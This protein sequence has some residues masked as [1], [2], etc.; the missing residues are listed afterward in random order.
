MEQKRFLHEK[1][2]LDCFIAFLDSS[3]TIQ[4]VALEGVKNFLK[5]GDQEVFENGKTEN[6]YQKELVLRGAGKIIRKLQDSKDEE[7]SY[8]ARE[9]LNFYPLESQDADSDSSY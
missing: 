7:I 9:I 2:V 5:A 8:K 1:G 6:P 4:E 3:V